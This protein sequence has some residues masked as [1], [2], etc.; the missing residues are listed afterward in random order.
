MFSEKS[1]KSK[2]EV[3]VPHGLLE[4]RKDSDYKSVEKKKRATQT[5]RT[6]ENDPFA[7]NVLRKKGFIL[8]KELQTHI[9]NE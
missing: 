6:S 5:Q 9:G 3:S 7:L 4:K 1:P 2:R 8:C